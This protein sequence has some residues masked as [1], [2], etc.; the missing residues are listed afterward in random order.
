AYLKQWITRAL[1]SR[2]PAFV[3]LAGQIRHHFEGIVAAVE[4]GLSNA[5]LEGINSKIRLIQR[6]GHGYHSVQA[7][8]AVIYLC[9]GGIT[10]ELPTRP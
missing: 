5:R 10:I 9:L 7:L 3:N 6:R 8:A 1:R 4:L 2:I